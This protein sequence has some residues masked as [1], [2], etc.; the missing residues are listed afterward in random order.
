[1]PAV[2]PPPQV[3]PGGYPDQSLRVATILDA[4]GTAGILGADGRYLKEAGLLPLEA[5][6]MYCDVYC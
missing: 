6:A 3:D 2:A 5:T 4:L 1:M